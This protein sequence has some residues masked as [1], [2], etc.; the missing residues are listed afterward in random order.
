MSLY[1]RRTM[2]VMAPHAPL[3][4]ALAAHLAGPPGSGMWITGLRPKG[5]GEPADRY[6]SSGPVAE[7]FA[8][9]LTD[10][11]A[12]WGAV[13]MAQQTG[14]ALPANAP[15]ITHE[16]CVALVESAVVVDLDEEAP[17]DTFARLELELVP[18]EPA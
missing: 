6:V 15:A 10:A 9:L 11:E 7:E 5:S 3:A 14:M 12:L 18:G 13:Q 2:I 17:F 1:I 4:R 16:Q 8:P